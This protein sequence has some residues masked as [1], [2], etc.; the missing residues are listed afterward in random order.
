MPALRRLPSPLSAW[1][2]TL[3]AW[4]PVVARRPEHQVSPP[5]CG[6][7]VFRT[8]GHQL[9]GLGERSARERRRPSLKHLDGIGIM[10]LSRRHASRVHWQANLLPKLDYVER[11]SCLRTDLC[12]GSSTLIERRG[13]V[14][15][16]NTDDLHRRD[17]KRARLTGCVKITAR[18]V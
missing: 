5:E 10:K 9:Q 15:V 4:E 14:E 16:A 12:E 2:G 13:V 18:Q 11:R 3:V 17:A 6:V 7:S 1:R 8:E